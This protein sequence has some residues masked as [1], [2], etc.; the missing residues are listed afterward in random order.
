MCEVFDFV[1]F[2]VVNLFW[3]WVCRGGLC[4]GYGEVVDGMLKDGFWDVYNDYVMGMVVE[5][6]VDN[7]SV[8]WE[9]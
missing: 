4:F 3:I 6:C 5:F 9:V 8:F 1:Y 7:Y 2:D